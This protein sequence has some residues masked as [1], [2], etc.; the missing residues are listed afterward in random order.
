MINQFHNQDEDPNIINSYLDLNVQSDFH[1]NDEL[2]TT[3]VTNNEHLGSVDKTYGLDKTKSSRNY[4]QIVENKK[5]KINMTILPKKIDI[6]DSFNISNLDNSL[7]L[8]DILNNNDELYYKPQIAN[9]SQHTGMN[10]YNKY[11]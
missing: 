1:Y 3:I 6:T 8:S 9:V 7:E 2:Q 4:P 5:C 11:I 10:I